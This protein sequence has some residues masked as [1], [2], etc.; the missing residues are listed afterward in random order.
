MSFAALVLLEGTYSDRVITAERRENPKL[1]LWGELFSLLGYGLDRLDAD[2]L[3]LTR[4]GVH[5][6]IDETGSA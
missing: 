3:G 1:P 6:D 4:C 2:F 5:T